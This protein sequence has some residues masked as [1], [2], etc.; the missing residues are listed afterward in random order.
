MSKIKSLSSAILFALLIAMLIC[1]SARAEEPTATDT[2]S[3]LT[4]IAKKIESGGKIASATIEAGGN[5]A[6]VVED[7]TGKTLLTDE[8]AQKAKSV[9][10]TGADIAQSVQTVAEPF[11]DT[12]AGN[13]IYVIAGAALAIF[14]AL[15]GAFSKKEK[16]DNSNLHTN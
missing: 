4:S 5:V 13:I 8:Q 16:T 15:S 12:Q 1:V 3:N 9:C 7:E 14:L 2:K 10:D 6:R 11:K